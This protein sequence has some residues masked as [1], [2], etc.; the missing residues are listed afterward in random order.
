[1]T[2]PIGLCIA[3]FLGLC[4]ACLFFSFVLFALLWLVFQDKAAQ[5]ETEIDIRALSTS[6]AVQQNMSILDDNV[7]FGVLALLAENEFVDESVKVIL[8][9]W[10]FVGT[11]DN[12]AVISRI[13]VG[14][15]AE[16][17]TKV[18]DDVCCAISTRV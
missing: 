7:C 4:A 5:L 2:V 14:L 16:L 12:P 6:F 1:M 11:I 13:S 17:E 3:I 10:G 18:F 8:K 15:S 9:L